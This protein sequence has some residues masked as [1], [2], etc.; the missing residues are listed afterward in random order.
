MSLSSCCGSCA[1]NWKD[2]RAFDT[3]RDLP[4]P[5]EMINF[6]CLLPAVVGLLA[7][8]SLKLAVLGLVL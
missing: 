7:L 3:L 5:G 1:N 8:S 2:N 4:A 6:S